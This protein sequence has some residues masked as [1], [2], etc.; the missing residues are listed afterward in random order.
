MSFLGDVICSTRNMLLQGFRSLPVLLAGAILTLGLTQAN[1]NLLFFFVGLFLITPV[2]TLL[3]NIIIE[4]IMKIWPFTNID[5]EFWSTIAN[6]EQCDLFSNIEN[7]LKV[8]NSRMTV[9]PSYWMTI[10]AFFFSYLFY[11]AENLYSKPAI[12]NAPAAEVNARKSQSM[13]SMI[14]LIVCGILFTI[15]RYGTSCERAFGIIVSWLLGGSLAYG[16]YKFMRDCGF[17]RLDD[18]FGISNQ[19]LP[20][21]TLEDQDPTVCVPQGD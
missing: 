2:A 9:V 20:F 6:I 18:L 12:K 5:Q 1:Y 21:E 10:L 14:I 4:F 8:S 15:L 16:W 7:D 17:G 13:L 11:N 3:L 19:L